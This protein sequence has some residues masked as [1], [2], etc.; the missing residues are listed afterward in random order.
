MYLFTFIVCIQKTCVLLSS[1][2]VDHYGLE[3]KDREQ[4]CQGII[5]N[6]MKLFMV[7][8]KSVFIL[9]ILHLLSLITY[10]CFVVERQLS[11]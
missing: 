8:H 10:S 6:I 5:M 11:D 1:S 9:P 7:W 2:L 4:L 3:T